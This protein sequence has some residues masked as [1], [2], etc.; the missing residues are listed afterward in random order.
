MKT[1]F[2]G[3]CILT[4]VACCGNAGA[5]DVTIVEQPDTSRNRTMLLRQPAPATAEPANQ[6]PHRAVRP[7]GSVRKQIELQ[8]GT[9]LWDNSARSAG[10]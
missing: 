3:I 7:E 9:V 4:L 8:A 5:D 10:F 6:A 1:G 2:H